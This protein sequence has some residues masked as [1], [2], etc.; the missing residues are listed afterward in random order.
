MC[1]RDSSKARCT[2]ELLLLRLKSLLLLCVLAGWF[3]QDRKERE[4]NEQQQR[5]APRKIPR[6]VSC[7]TSISGRTTSKQAKHDVSE[8]KHDVVPRPHDVIEAKHDVIKA[9]HDV[10]EAK[11]DVICLLQFAKSFFPL[12][13]RRSRRRRGAPAT[14]WL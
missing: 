4:A 11:H 7:V 8:A 14:A 13:F 6:C 3:L 5:E 9:K 12:P 1:I 2:Q 10:I